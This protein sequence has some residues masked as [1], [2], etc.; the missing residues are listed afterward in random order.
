MSTTHNNKLLKA[1]LI[2]AL[3]G[4]LCGWFFGTA[5]Q[6]VEWLGI[7]F[8]DT[9]KMTIIPL[10]VAAVISGVASLG[11]VRKLGKLGGLTVTYYAATTALA[12]LTGL[13]LVNI[14]QPGTGYD[15]QHTAVAGTVPGKESI[16]FVD[17]IQSL[18]SPNL[19][20]A[21][22]ETQLLPIIIF[23]LIFGAALTTTGEKGGPVINFFHGLNEVMMKI[24][25]WIM[26]FAPVGIFAMIASRLGQAGGGAAFWNEI[27]QVG[28]YIFTVVLGLTI[29]FFV[30]LGIL[31]FFT[32]RGFAYVNTMLR[33]LLT[34]FGTSSSSAT[35]P[36]TIECAIEA[37][38]DKRAVKFVLPLGATV[39]MDGTALYEAVAV[40]FIAQAYAVSMSFSEQVIIFITATLAAIGAAGIP[41]AGLVTMVIVL[42]A[43]NLPLEGI[44]MILA[45]DWFLDRLRTTVN[46]W[47]DSAGAAILENVLE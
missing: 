6:A 15:I 19:I 16:G 25:I 41:Q 20:A 39:N 7:L 26:Y 46:I 2:G 43:V 31:Y 30:L 22:A 4:I 9:L 24:V 28:W 14:I 32:R 42:T 12:V 40:M 47:G 37:G 11:D 10:I 1:I 44:G 3:A 29:H 5:M 35:L 17:I 21:A 23:C 33:A 38:V 27:T 18:I 45:V 13:I 36:L 8:L 34:A